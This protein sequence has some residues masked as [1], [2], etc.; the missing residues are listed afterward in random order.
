MARSHDWAVIEAKA[1]A[2]YAEDVGL[3]LLV[4]HYVGLAQLPLGIELVSP[5]VV[6]A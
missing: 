5:A 6:L 3:F 2:G 4:L 1:A